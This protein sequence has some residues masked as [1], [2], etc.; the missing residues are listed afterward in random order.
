MSTVKKIRFFSVTQYEQEAEWLR[1]M[2]NQGLKYVSLAIPGIYTFETCEPED[3]VYQLDYNK[4]GLEN[5]EEYIQMYADCGWEYL[6]DV[7]GYSYFR[8]P[9]AEMDGEETIFCDDESR[10]EMID[11][12]WKGRG[13]ALLL[14]FFAVVIPNTTSALSRY[15]AG[16]DVLTLVIIWAILAVAYLWILISFALYYRKLKNRIDGN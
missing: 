10:L 11:R 2:H 12:V 3:V 8:K 13:L 4:E 9:S 15:A 14:L 16:E 7:M 6:G 5:K 1:K